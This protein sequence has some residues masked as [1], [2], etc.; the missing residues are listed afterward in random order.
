[1]QLE[2]L[3]EQ[4]LISIVERMLTSAKGVQHL[5]YILLNKTITQL[6]ASLCSML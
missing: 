6:F 4:Y 5:D 3:P 2:E 1:V